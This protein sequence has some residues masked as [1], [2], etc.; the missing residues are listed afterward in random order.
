MHAA[1][2]MIASGMLAALLL[3]PAPAAAPASDVSIQAET[4]NF[5]RDGSWTL[6]GGVQINYGTDIRITSLKARGVDKPGN[7]TEIDLSDTVHVEFR[8][9]VL[10]A[11]AAF[12]V[13]RNEQLVSVAVKGSQAR[14][15][16]PR[17]DS[18]RRVEGR[19]S[20]I[21]YN[22]TNNEVRF[23]GT[24]Y[25]TDGRFDVNSD[26]VIYNLETGGFRGPLGGEVRRSG[27]GAAPDVPPPRTPDRSNAQ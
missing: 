19:A 17:K 1:A 5:E 20:A 21:E 2:V 7:L 23:T 15:S 14:F 3:A 11:D 8:G 10:D 22:S 4:W 16:H 18:D 27:R 25:W 6:T 24:T 9:A 26:V 12:V 13:V